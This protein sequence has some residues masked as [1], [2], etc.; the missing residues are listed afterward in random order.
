MEMK[1]SSIPEKYSRE[2]DLFEQRQGGH[3]NPDGM[4]SSLWLE[5]R[6]HKGTSSKENHKGRLRLNTRGPY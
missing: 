1:S 5:H 2:R 4:S 3:R 6:V